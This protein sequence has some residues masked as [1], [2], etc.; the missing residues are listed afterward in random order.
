MD[1]YRIFHADTHLQTPN[2]SFWTPNPQNSMKNTKIQNVVPGIFRTRSE[3]TPPTK[4]LRPN[5]LAKN[6][7]MVILS[8]STCWGKVRFDWV[9]AIEIPLFHEKSLS[10]FKPSGN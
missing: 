1:S 8:L 10:H 5:P 4:I 9:F 2:S 7:S 3:K 6:D